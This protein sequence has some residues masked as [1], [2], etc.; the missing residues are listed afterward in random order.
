MLSE[1]NLESFL[2]A[3]DV[4][5][6]LLRRENKLDLLDKATAIKAVAITQSI[7]RNNAPDDTKSAAGKI[8]TELKALLGL[9]RCGNN[10]DAFM[11]DTLAPLIVPGMPTYIALHKA[12]IDRL[13]V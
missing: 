6:A 5:E 1:R 10:T 4:I 13:I 2:F 7:A 12:I 8:Y 11:R 9:K 3:D